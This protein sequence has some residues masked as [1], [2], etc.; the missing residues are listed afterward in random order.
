MLS[1][2]V[3]ANWAPFSPVA[4][5]LFARPEDVSVHYTVVFESNGHPTEA[6]TEEAEPPTEMDLRELVAQALSADTSLPVDIH[7]LS[8]GSGEA[9][10]FLQYRSRPSATCKMS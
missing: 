9:L 1:T 6:G 2:L 4:L 5:L 3:D 8:F 7:S 10:F